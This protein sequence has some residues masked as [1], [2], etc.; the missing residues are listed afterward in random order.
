VVATNSAGSLTSDPAVVS[1]GP[2]VAPTI[3]D[4]PLSLQIDPNTTNY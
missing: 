1:V 2:V 4:Q 3:L